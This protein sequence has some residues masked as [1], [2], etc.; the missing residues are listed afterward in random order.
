MFTIFSFYASVTMD[1]KEFES[2]TIVWSAPAPGFC[3]LLKSA[4][5]CGCCV[6]VVCLVRRSTFQH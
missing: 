5:V 4:V 1:D 6:S 3:R 2:N